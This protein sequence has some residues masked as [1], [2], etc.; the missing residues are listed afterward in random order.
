MAGLWGLP[1]MR[2]V[3]CLGADWLP[4]EAPGHPRHPTAITTAM[5]ML[6]IDLCGQ[7][8]N[9]GAFLR[10]TS[11]GHCATVTSALYSYIDKP[12]SVP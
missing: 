4:V 7:G 11:A 8:L 2:A 5:K 10:V 6:K 9:D 1:A 12:N 3:L